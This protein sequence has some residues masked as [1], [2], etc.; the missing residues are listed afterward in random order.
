[1]QDGQGREQVFDLHVHSTF[2]DGSQ[3]VEQ[4]IEEARRVGIARLGVVDHDCLRQLVRVRSIAH[5]ATF[6]VLAGVEVSCR[7]AAT[8][9]CVHILGYGLEATPD[10]SGPLELI[11]EK[12]LADR[13]ANSLWQAWTIAREGVEFNGHPCCL[14][15]L[16]RAAHGSTGLY[17]Q[18]IMYAL[19]ALDYN[20]ERYQACYR[21]LFKG[22][23]IAQRDISYP[24]A[25]KAVRAIREQ[26]G[27]AVLAHPGQMDSWESVPTLVRA[28]LTGIE[29]YHPDHDRADETRARE[30]A[31]DYGLF[32]TGGSDCHGRYGA[33][34]LGACTIDEDEAGAAVEELFSRERA[35]AF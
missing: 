17:K 22:G 6:P 19:T 35:F 25:T 2:S 30:A 21:S 27:V 23:G 9:R 26:G 3:S 32:M 14:G 11:V 28:G 24:E 31:A 20:D 12:T 4:I 16:V 34:A 13:V 15:E 7:D 8:G 18:H 10:A 1:M 5:E 33:P 29:V